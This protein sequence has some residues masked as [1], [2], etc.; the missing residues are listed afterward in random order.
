MANSDLKNDEIKKVLDIAPYSE[1]NNFSSQIS[2]IYNDLSSINNDL[3]SINNQISIIGQ[4]LNDLIYIPCAMY[5]KTSD[6]NLTSGWTNVSW[7]IWT[8][9]SNTSNIIQSSS[10]NFTVNTDGLYFLKVILA[11]SG[12]TNTTLIK[13]ININLSRGGNVKTLTQS[14]I[15]M[16]F[17]TYWYLNAQIT[18][19]FKQGDII[20]IE[21]FSQ[22]TGTQIINDPDPSPNDWVLNSTFSWF[23]VSDT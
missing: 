15:L 17:S 9:W 3:S 1:V 8:P 2:I 21:T 11:I 19:E 7:D 16:T 18:Y 6:Q 13:A 14:S 4:N 12:G 22:F 5:Y 23:W 20:F 10:T